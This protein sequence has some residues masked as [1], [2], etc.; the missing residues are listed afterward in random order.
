MAR[1]QVLSLVGGGIRGAF[2]A[3][4]LCALEEKL[5]RPI[6][7]AFDMIA[8]TSTG[9]IIAAGLA[10][11]KTGHEVRQFYDEC[12]EAIFSPRP[13]FQGAGMMYFFF[14]LANFLFHRRTG[15]PLDPMFRARYCPFA[16]E[17]TLK[18]A[19]GDTTVGQARQSRLII[20]S[21]NLTQGKP[22]VF[23]TPHLPIGVENRDLK[24]TDVLLAATAAPTYFPHKVMPDGHAY[25]DGGLWATDPSMLAL[26]EAIRVQHLD[27]ATAAPG[28]FHR[29]DIHLLSIGTG[30]F[31]FSLSPP[32][33][34]AGS[35]FWAQHVADVMGT[36]QVEGVHRPLEFQL[37]DRYTHLNFD[38]PENWPMDDTSYISDLFEQGEL[39]ADKEFDRLNESFLN[40]QREAYPVFE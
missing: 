24:I 39:V 30:R 19:F 2:T 16:L 32:G 29:H 4:L 20:P 40:H 5:G 33:A 35:L 21:V 14:P 26:S 9:G 18:S 7:E 38:M 17:D 31:R 28:T 8:G 1:F 36:S 23:R 34:D 25:A 22:H 12:G 3:A 10:S 37:G 6:Y 15:Q 13:R 11:G 27:E